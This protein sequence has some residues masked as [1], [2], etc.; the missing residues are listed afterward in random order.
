MMRE[1]LQETQI[2][3]HSPT[4]IFHFIYSISGEAVVIQIQKV[5]LMYLGTL[6]FGLSSCDPGHI[7]MQELPDDSDDL[8][9]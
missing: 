3:T 9:G 6:A 8:L 5:E 7:T 1:H 2:D 4:S